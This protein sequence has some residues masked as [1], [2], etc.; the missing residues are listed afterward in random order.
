MSILTM[1]MSSYEVERADEISS[2]YSEEILC[3]G[4]IPN[5]ARHQQPP[6][7]TS[8][9]ASLAVV[10]VEAFLRKMYASQR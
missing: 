6:E 7:K 8:L 5:L 4:W 1:D 3:A 2:C 9:S 10:D